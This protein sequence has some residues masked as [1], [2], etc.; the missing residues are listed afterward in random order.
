MYTK[1][2]NTM[3][4]ETNYHHPSIDLGQTQFSHLKDYFKLGFLRKIQYEGFYATP[5]VN[6]SIF[7]SR[8]TEI[9]KM[10]KKI[11]EMR[12]WEY[13]GPLVSRSVACMLGMALGDSLGH[14]LEFVPFDYERRTIKDLDP[15]Y[16]KE[17]FDGQFLNRFKLKPGQW[18]DDTSMGLC[19]A[20]SLLIHQRLNC[21]DLRLRFYLWWNYGLNNGLRF[22][23]LRNSK[24]SIGLRGTVAESLEEFISKP[25]EGTQTG[26]ESSNGSGSI[27]R[28]A[29]LPIFYHSNLKLGIEAAGIQSLTTHKG[30][31]AADCCK[32]ITYII[33]KALYYEEIPIIDSLGQMF[34]ARTF[35]DRLDYK[36][37]L[38][39][40]QQNPSLLSLVHS[41]QQAYTFHDKW[42]KIPEDRNW[43]W[44]SS[45]FRYSPTRATQ[46]PGYIG[47]YAVDA[48]AM[49]LHCIYHTSSFTECVLKVVNLGGDA[50][51]VGSVAA[52]IAGAIY[53]L[54]AIPPHWINQLMHW[55]NHG[56]I[57]LRAL[58]LLGKDIIPH[59]WEESRLLLEFNNKR[60]RSRRKL[61]G[62]E[63][64]CCCCTI[65]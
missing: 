35:L 50:D 11:V 55:D 37:L 2:W 43:N 56:E 65:F 5:L 42:N 3:E 19:L 18:T 14:L 44:K 31:E 7:Q 51:S 13:W 48:L 24:S 22:D 45:K 58:L 32:L 16:W 29:P 38:P 6:Y 10:K 1:N 25:E 63:K 53:G 41:Q 52:Q 34:F 46:Q 36:E 54:A 49:A 57:P 12:N 23:K 21:I 4:E 33:I 64:F 40:I 26:S 9:L 47:S 28:L 62:S 39:A 61:N 60:K 59:F 8:A 30:Q 15:L 17:C 27:M 20:D